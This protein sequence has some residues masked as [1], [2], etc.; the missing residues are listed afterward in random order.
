MV[1]SKKLSDHQNH[2]VPIGETGESVVRCALIYGPNAAGKSN[3]IK[4]MNYAQQ[5]IRGNYRVRTLETFRFDRRFVR[6][7]AAE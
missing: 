2:L 6:A 3:L 7:P 1:A 4:A 5:A